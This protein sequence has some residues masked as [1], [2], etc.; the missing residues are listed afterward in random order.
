MDLSNIRAI[1]NNYQDARLI[2]LKDWKRANEVEPHDHGGPY[3]VSQE[4]YDPHDLKARYNEF[5]L[6][7]SGKWLSLS[8]FFKL[9]ND[10]RRQEFIFGTAAEV[11]QMMDSLRG[12]PE[13]EHGQPSHEPDEAPEIAELK[14]A[15]E[16]SKKAAQG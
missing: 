2:S 7:R 6:G 13:I 16:N 4:G 11:I 10:I 3:I 8:M 14:I 15:V 1:T 12:N 5:V 9:P